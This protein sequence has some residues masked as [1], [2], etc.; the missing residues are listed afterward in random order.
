MGKWT[1]PKFKSRT[2]KG[3]Y[4]KIN[5]QRVLIL[6]FTLANGNVSEFVFD[7]HYAAKKAGWTYTR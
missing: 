7:T 2:Y 1:S 5:K 6:S 4:G 3:S